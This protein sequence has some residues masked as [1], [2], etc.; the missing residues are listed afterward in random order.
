MGSIEKKM[1]NNYFQIRK[2]SDN[3]CNNIVKAKFEKQTSSKKKSEI[4]IHFNSIFEEK[5]YVIALDFDGTMIYLDNRDEI[6]SKDI[7]KKLKR[8]NDKKIPILILTGRGSSVLRQIPITDYS[9]KDYVF[10]AQYNG[11]KI[12]LGNGGVLN[13]IRIKENK[14]YHKIKL[15]LKENEIPFKEKISSFVIFGETELF[16]T[17][18][19]YL[20]DLK[21]WRVVKTNYSY[22]IIPNE[23]SKYNAL[24]RGCQLFN[25]HGID[26]ILKIGDSGDKEGND[27]DFLKL[28]NSFSV[29][30]F[31]PEIETNFPLVDDNCEF[32]TGPDGLKFILEYLSI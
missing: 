16:D 27:Y 7:L 9:F 24:I 29:G 18:N 5:F 1:K 10:F 2:F 15:F 8:L 13:E 19:S 23:V 32:L 17:I 21:G 4:G 20:C 26:S 3:I 14:N 11:G 6:T 30:S 31:S 28:K 22:D 25:L 12:I